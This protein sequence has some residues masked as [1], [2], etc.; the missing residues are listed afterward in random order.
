MHHDALADLGARGGDPGS[1]R[2]DDA[3]RLVAGDRRL[4]WRGE[5]A[6]RPAGFRPAVLVQ[7]AAA[8]PRSFH[9]DDDLALARRRIGELH[10]LEL[11]FAGKDTPRRIALAHLTLSR[12]RGGG[13]G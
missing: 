4:A 5:A 7:V 10:Q 12:E 2:G 6:R 3:A 11:A 9:L 8:H 13:G 1:D